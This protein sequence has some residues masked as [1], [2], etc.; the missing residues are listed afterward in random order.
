VL[1]NRDLTLLDVVSSTTETAV[2]SYSVPA[3]QLGTDSGVRATLV[4]T[5]L[6]NASNSYSTQI[7]VRF[8]GTALFDDSVN[9]AKNSSPRAVLIIVDLFNAGST[10]SQK[11]GG[12]ITIG[13]LSAATVGFG[14]LGAAQSSSSAVDQPVYGTSGV[15]TTSAK[16]LEITVQHSNSD[17]ALS[18]KREMFFTEFLQ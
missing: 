3:N 17:A 15:D 14:D 2:Y 6:N 4:G 8:G 12:K 1:L 7:R 11:L 9:F 18:F 16:T 5:Y 10:G 13:Q